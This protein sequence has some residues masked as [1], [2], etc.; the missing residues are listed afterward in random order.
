MLNDEA[1]RDRRRQIFFSVAGICTAFAVAGLVAL[2]INNVIQPTMELETRDLVEFSGDTFNIWYHTGSPYQNE[3]D[4]LV[5]TLQA[6]L[7][8]ILTRLDVEQSEIPLPIDVIVHDTPEQ[9]QQTTLRRKSA[10][11]MY[12][13]YA[14]IDL[15]YGEDPYQRLAELV[16]AFGWGDC[17]SQILYWGMLLNVLEPTRNFDVALSAAPPRLLRSLDDL[18]KLE[19]ADAFGETLYERYQSPFSSRLAMG[20]L[21]GIAEFRTMFTK[22]GVELQEDTIPFLEA[23]SLVHYLVEC[24]GGLQ[25]FRMIWG[26]G[27]T[28]A[29][30]EKLACGSMAEI[31]DS[32]RMTIRSTNVQDGDYEYYRALFQY[33]AGDV[34][35]AAR[36]TAAWPLVGLTQE[37]SILAVR[38]QLS[39]GNL[40]RAARFTDA[41]VDTVQP[42]LKEWVSLYSGWNAMSDGGF[43][44]MGRLPEDE[45]REQLEGVRSAY[46]RVVGLLGFGENELPD[47]VTVF[48]YAT[49]AE[50]DVGA[51]ILPFDSVN[52]TIWH[53]SPEDSLIKSFADTLPSYVTGK[54]TASNMLQSGLRAALATG[55]EDL[56]QAGCEILRAGEWT[57]LWR[58]GFGGTSDRILNTETGLMIQ[59]VLDEYG[60]GV[61]RDLWMATA[62]MGGGQSLETAFHSVLDVT[63]TDIEQAIVNT[64]L[65]CE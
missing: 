58:I 38:A 11:A 18:L 13:F 65:N 29:Q 15:L 30:I 27:T 44:V 24:S 19:A 22:P 62:K 33:E 45:L 43:T 17:H 57:P 59:Y 54:D 47:H 39:V 23:A 35:A 8:E 49:A 40:E 48:L 60:P 31:E 6:D 42:T 50:R 34:E 28:E 2:L 46:E 36:R 53:V 7:D 32:W 16:L 41:A 5:D 10:N 4:G 61:I 56:L 21:E 63:R 26:P 12:S 55:R 64:V 37:K 14:M 20:S 25:S 52:R 3:R 1:R 9:L 51:S